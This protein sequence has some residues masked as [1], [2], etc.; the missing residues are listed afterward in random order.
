VPARAGAAVLPL[1]PRSHPVAAEHP[2]HVEVTHP[3]HV[4]VL[5]VD[6][7]EVD[8]EVAEAEQA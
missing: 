5:E 8:H 6:H 3:R 4:R 2:R 1:S 7:L